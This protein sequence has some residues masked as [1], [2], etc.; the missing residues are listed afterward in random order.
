MTSEVV[1]IRGSATVATAVLQMRDQRLRALIVERAHEQDAYGILTET[2]IV[3]KV[4]AFGKD[5]QQVRVFE[6]M[7]K[8]CIVVNPDLGVEYVARLFAEAGISRA[9]VIQGQ[10]LGIISVTDILTKGNFVEEPQAPHLAQKIQAAI[11]QAL[12]ICAENGSASQECRRAWE[13]VET[14]QVEAAYQRSQQLPKTAFEEYGEAHP[15]IYDAW[16]S[17]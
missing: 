16:C 15:E 5:P 2:D 3:C 6:V 1:T 11:D 14:L 9:P 10:L 13:S 7:T 4:T 17:G 8:P 12:N